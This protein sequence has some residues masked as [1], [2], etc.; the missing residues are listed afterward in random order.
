MFHFWA[1]R[2]RL[3]SA[4]KTMAGLQSISVRLLYRVG[5]VAWKPTKAVTYTARIANKSCAAFMTKGR[6]NR[7]PIRVRVTHTKVINMLVRFIS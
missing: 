5:Q 2:H 6:E 7:L 3:T 1:S 4:R